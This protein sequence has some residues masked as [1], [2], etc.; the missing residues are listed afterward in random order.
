MLGH[1]SPVS[2]AIYT[3]FS[4]AAAVAAVQALPAPPRL[5][6]VPKESTS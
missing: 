6:A 2:T 3:Q 4:P 1:Q 5:R